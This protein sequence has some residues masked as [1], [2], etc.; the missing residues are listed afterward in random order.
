M[1]T[2]KTRVYHQEILHD[3]VELAQR[4]HAPFR[5]GDPYVGTTKT[6]YLIK[7]TVFR[8]MVKDWLLRHPELTP[9]DFRQLLASLSQGTTS[10]EFWLIGELLQL[11]PRWRATCGPRQVAS[12]LDHAQGWA[13]VDSI[14]QS[15]FTAQDLLAD[16]KTWKSELIALAKSKNVHQ[17]RASLVLLTGPVKESAEA[18]LAGLAFANIGRLQHERDILITKAISWLLRNLIKH[19]RQEVETYLTEHTDSL[20]PIAIRETQNKLRTG[21]KSGR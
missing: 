21:V 11:A 8:H 18:R 19:H 7:T 4:E 17:R 12:W 5:E 20:S 2:S 9:V 3:L 13:E 10:N 16:W 14:C 1:K 6:C 15:K